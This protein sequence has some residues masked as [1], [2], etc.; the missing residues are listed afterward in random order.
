MKLRAKRQQEQDLLQVSVADGLQCGWLLRSLQALLE[1]RVCLLLVTCFPQVI[2]VWGNEARKPEPLTPLLLAPGPSELGSGIPNFLDPIFS[3]LLKEKAFWGLGS[4]AESCCR[5]K[6]R[7]WSN[8]NALEDLKES[9]ETYWRVG[10]KGRA[11]E[12]IN[13]KS[14][15][16]P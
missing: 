2:A 10:N 5:F 1:C 6:G 16:F 14:L 8:Q 3:P 13:L 7:D 4:L 9:R 11:G 15:Q 12:V